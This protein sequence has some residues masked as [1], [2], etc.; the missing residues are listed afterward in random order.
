M[1]KGAGM[2]ASYDEMGGESPTLIAY[3]PMCL[4]SESSCSSN[5]DEKILIF[6]GKL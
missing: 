6:H 3:G 2:E 1:T 5:Y 4:R